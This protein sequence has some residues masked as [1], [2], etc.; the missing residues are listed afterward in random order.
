MHEREPG[1][2]GGPGRPA[3]S[4]EAAG[5]RIPGDELPPSLLET[6]D[7]GAR[8]PA[9]PRP[10]ATIVLIRE[11]AAGPEVLLLRRPGR[12]GF[13]ANAW[14][15]P[16]G[17][18]DEADRS[19]ELQRRT[20][21]PAADAW[22]ARMPGLTA[23]EAMGTGIAAI[24]EAW[25]ET[26]LLLATVAAGADDRGGRAA[27]ELER[28]RNALLAGG[29]DFAAVVSGHGLL[30]RTDELV[31]LAHWITPE[32]EPRRFDT[33]FFL[34]PASAGWPPGDPPEVRLHA[35]ELEEARWM[36]PADAVQANA[37]GELPMLPPTLHTLR[38]LAPFT[39]FREMKEALRDAPVT[40]ILPR[41]RADGDGVVLE[42][43]IPRLR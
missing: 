15:F 43:P 39:S 17:V 11:G 4:E 14:V 32:A 16:G 8:S 9:V 29:T 12:S 26:G 31:Y 37:A 18:V 27:V 33:R 21:G 3:A 34:A 35:A 36:S 30:L 40:P 19:A 25:E 28:A 24:R 6:L 1:T 13:A 7:L 41:F 38:R 10:S 23:G 5:T 22:S 20:T 2:L 42:I